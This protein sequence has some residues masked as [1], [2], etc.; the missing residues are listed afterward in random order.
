MDFKFGPHLARR[1]SGQ[2]V[3]DSWRQRPFLIHART[4]WSFAYE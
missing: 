3:A 1:Y 4:G 2:G